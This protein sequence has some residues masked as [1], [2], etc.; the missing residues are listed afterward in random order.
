MRLSNMVSRSYRRNRHLCPTSSLF[1]VELFQVVSEERVSDG[2][3]D[4]PDILCVRGAGEMCV[5]GFVAP[6][7]QI[8]VH[9]Q[10]EVSRSFGVTLRPCGGEHSPNQRD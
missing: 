5:K 2:F 6:A 10:D 9:L 4:H 1:E 7:V 3:E 8:P